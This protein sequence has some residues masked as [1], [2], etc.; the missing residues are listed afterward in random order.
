MLRKRFVALFI[1]KIKTPKRFGFWAAEIC[2]DLMFL[3]FT[4]TCMGIC[5]KFTFAMCTMTVGAFGCH[6]ETFREKLDAYFAEHAQEIQKS[7]R[8]WD[9]YNLHEPEYRI[10]EQEL[11]DVVL[12]SREK[13]V[14]YLCLSLKHQIRFFW[15]YT[16][17]MYMCKIQ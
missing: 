6:G 5:K 9:A 13:V 17:Q 3:Q 8:E 12:R 4:W 14:C 2:C 16:Q 15:Y 10:T 1:L 11:K 7:I